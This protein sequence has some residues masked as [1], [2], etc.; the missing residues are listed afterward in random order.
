MSDLG[1]GHGERLRED[2]ARILISWHLLCA[3]QKKSRGRMC[4]WC[5]Q[6]HTFQ[7]ICLT[8]WLVLHT[9]FI[10]LTV[11]KRYI[12]WGG[13]SPHQH[14]AVISCNARDTPHLNGK[15]N[16]SGEHYLGKVPSSSETGP[17]ALQW[18]QWYGGAPRERVKKGSGCNDD[19]HRHSPSI[20]APAPLSR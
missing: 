3:Q 20:C 1:I 8:D 18:A 19:S 6:T 7:G 17:L 4:A 11:C 12:L 13:N 14:S 5:K 2:T 9:S 10:I 15:L 16:C